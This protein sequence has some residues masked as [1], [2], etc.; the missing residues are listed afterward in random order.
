MGAQRPNTRAQPFDFAQGE[1]PSLIALGSSLAA[2]ALPVRRHGRCM[3]G[4]LRSVTMLI[5]SGNSLAYARAISTD[6][7]G[8]SVVWQAGG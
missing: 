4:A 5:P 6:H 2:D 7:M 3:K 8:A 1:A